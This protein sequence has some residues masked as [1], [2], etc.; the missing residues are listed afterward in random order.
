[1]EK[2]IPLPVV[3]FHPLTRKSVSRWVAYLKALVP[4]D[5]FVIATGESQTVMIQAKRLD[6]F[7]VFNRCPEGMRVWLVPADKIPT[8]P[9]R[10]WLA[11]EQRQVPHQKE[12]P[13]PVKAAVAEDESFDVALL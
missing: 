11:S 9:K 5:S 2:G 7:L 12:T 1:M 13:P 4:G 10:L 3:K 6:L 8:K